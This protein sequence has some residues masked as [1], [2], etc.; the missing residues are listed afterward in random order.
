MRAAF[1]W[2]VLLNVRVIAQGPLEQ[3]YT[4]ENLRRTYGGQV[5]L[6]DAVNGAP[7]AAS[8]AAR[9]ASSEASGAGTGASTLGA[10]PDGGLSEP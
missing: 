2:L 9:S 10:G 5:A 8:V 6:L 4:M 1:D 3:V 7:S